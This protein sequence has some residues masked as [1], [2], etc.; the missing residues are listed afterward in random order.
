MKKILYGILIASMAVFS[1]CES[2]TELQPKGKNLLTSVNELDML[3][4][5]TYSNL[6]LSGNDGN[7][8]LNEFYPLLTN[9]PDLISDPVKTTNS[10]WVTWDEQADRVSL[11]QNDYKYSDF[12]AVIGQVANPVLSRVDGAEGDPA[13][14]RRLKAEA[15][16]LRAWFGYLAV[17]YFAK[18][19]DPATAANDPGVPYPHEDDLLTTLNEKFTIQEVYDFILEDLDA[20]LKLESLPNEAINKMRVSL[21][22]ALA[23]KAKVL[24]S[25]RRYDEAESLATEVLGIE[26]RVD[27]HRL[28]M[29][30]AIYVRPK[31]ESVEDL[32]YTPNS[33]IFAAFSPEME[34]LFE[35]GS[36]LFD[37]YESDTR[38]YGVPVF[39]PAYYGLSVN[40]WIA[41]YTTYF[42]GAGLTT[43]DMYLILAECNLRKGNIARA[44]E[45]L[46][47]IR[48]NRIDPAV[49]QPW[50]GN[51][52]DEATAIKKLKQL[53]RT[54]SIFTCKSFI[55]IKRWNTEEK[56][57]ETLYK[58]LL[59]VDYELRP[60]S[61]LWIFPF[62]TNAT[63]LNPN[64]TQNY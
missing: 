16:V 11:A 52:T 42:S 4:N 41:M 1:S 8:L 49:Y 23:V 57:K 45:Q 59:G 43:V 17:N 24:M 28:A 12:Y 62:P 6:G 14:A 36:I 21:P 10:V 25:M 31:L 29:D 55:N 40:V 26:S 20:A 63:S 15:Y 64:L 38:E 34:D 56:Y 58:T 46:D 53:S 18:A 5:Y 7:I 60:D 9:I 44:M 27:N 33:P 32:F 30:E 3:L 51:V 13:I 22:F 2:F 19:Y 35:P 47:I 50:A 48:E 39:G 61:P 54:E 37:Y